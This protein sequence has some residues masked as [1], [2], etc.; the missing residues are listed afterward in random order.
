[1]P[2]QEQRPIPTGPARS[3]LEPL[4][5][6]PLIDDDDDEDEEIVLS[7]GEPATAPAQRPH[8]RPLLVNRPLSSSPSGD[9]VARSDSANQAKEAIK[10]FYEIL[11]G[12]DVKALPHK[13]HVFRMKPERGTYEDGEEVLLKGL[14]GEIIEYKGVE[15]IPDEDYIRERFGGGIYEIRVFGP[16]AAGKGWIRKVTKEVPIPGQPMLPPRKKTPGSTDAVLKTVLEQNE[17]ERLRLAREASDARERTDRL[18]QEQTKRQDNMMMTMLSPQKS[19]EQLLLER[20]ERRADAE[21]AERRHQET[22]AAAKAQHEMQL[23]QME[24]QQKQQ[25]E[26]RRLA[27]ATAHQQ[28][29][30]Q[31]EA[32][33]SAAALQAQQ[34]QAQLQMQMKQMEMQQTQQQAA[35]AQMQANTQQMMASQQQAAAA[36]QA[37]M[38]AAAQQQTNLL[39]G[40]M[41]DAN[42]EKSLFLEKLLSKKEDSGDGFDKLL[43]MKEVIDVFQGKGDEDSRPSWERMFDKVTEVLPKVP[44]MLQAAQQ[45]R[46]PVPSAATPTKKVLRAGSVAVAEIP[47]KAV[48]QIS[49]PQTTAP[50]ADQPETIT[51]DALANDLADFKQPT[52]EEFADIPTSLRILVQNIDFAIQRDMSA[53]Q[54][55]KQ[56]VRAWPPEQIKLLSMQTAEEVINT[57]AEKTPVSWKIVSPAG[58]RI[59]REIHALLKED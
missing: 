16:N 25:I 56:I 45:M 28:F 26:D 20:E 24:M 43:K 59:M 35:F 38:A 14:C 9:T 54:I 47:E 34:A 37:A 58:K 53:E 39:M 30:M 42:S 49:P 55:T 4:R 31:L 29:Q 22:L 17:K 57:I 5:P 1:M 51:V 13:I 19:S 3:I 40:M 48:E 21:K 18:M 7:S 33:K 32:Q 44:T 11:G 2:E 46:A 15:S 36:Q 27:E 8:E 12:L 50:A 41:T 10:D 23:K 6:E 52:P